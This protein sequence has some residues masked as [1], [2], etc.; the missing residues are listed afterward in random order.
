M[1]ENRRH[2]M[3][4]CGMNTKRR[5]E[6]GTQNGNQFCCAKIELNLLHEAESGIFVEWGESDGKARLPRAWFV[7]LE[8]G[9]VSCN[10]PRAL[11]L[12]LTSNYPFLSFP[13]YSLWSWPSIR[14]ISQRTRRAR[15]SR[16]AENS[17]RNQTVE[18]LWIAFN[19]LEIGFDRVTCC[20][21][22]NNEKRLS[23]RNFTSPNTTFFRPSFSEF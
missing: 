10:V 20:A 3:D 18:E 7:R 17:I 13:L 4:D 6:K 1:H 16:M 12:S 15:T 5:A 9:H 23:E 14:S 2:L 22:Q 11:L 21:K 8:K 19:C